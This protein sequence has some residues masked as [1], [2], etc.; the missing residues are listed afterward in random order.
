MFAPVQR[1]TR[2]LKPHTVVLS[3]TLVFAGVAGGAYSFRVYNRFIRK[4]QTY[5]R[6]ETGVSDS[7]NNSSIVRTLVN[8]HNHVAIGDSRS[9]VLTAHSEQETP[10]QEALLS[11]LVKGFFSGPVFMPERIALRLLG[12]RFVNFEGEFATRN[13]I[14]YSAHKRNE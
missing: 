9:V 12:L 11:A 3:A 8:P 13:D 4:Y 5:I 10:S 14:S 2:A 6:P 7:F 1:V